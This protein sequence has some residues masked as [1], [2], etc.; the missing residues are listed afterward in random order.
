L[1]QRTASAMRPLI[2]SKSDLAGGA[3]RAA[4]RLHCALVAAQVEST[5]LV[6]SRG[7]EDRRVQGPATSL[8]R[9]SA[10]IPAV[11]DNLPAMMQ[12]STNPINRSPAWTG[13]V[14]ARR[15]NAL[16]ADV[17]NLHWTCGGF[18]S[19]EEIGRITKPLVWTLHD[20]WA[21]CGAENYAADDQKA[22]F[23]S[24]YDRSN[25][26]PSDKGVDIDRW[27][28]SRKQR[29]W[30]H[31]FRIVTPSRWLADCVRDS[32]LMRD[33][34]V[35]VI[36]NPLD[37]EVFK[38]YPKNE[39]R[40]L[41]QLPE[42][43]KLVL[44]G[45]LKGGSDPRKGWDLLQ[46]ALARAGQRIP[47]LQGVIFGQGEPHSPP[48]LGLPLHWLGHINDD[49]K[50]AQLYSAVDVT[51]VPSRQENLPQVGTEA[52][53]CGCPV[54][55]FNT[56][57]L[58]DV[59]EHM[60]TGYLAQAFSIDDL[61]KG[62]AWVLQDA[63]LHADLSESARERARRFWS[64]KVVVPQYLEVYRQAISNFWHNL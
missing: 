29:S 50:L 40:K 57:G 20:M 34:P 56:A 22:R 52:Q 7:S 2:V 9:L 64:P 24:G 14:S 28:W 49:N 58:P 13:S 30:R 21:F 35:S 26:S 6:G 25:R 18:L 8:Q 53:A 37:T 43:A 17:I 4:H 41:L 38:P 19:I 12:Q 44:F 32:A 62:I 31:P 48:E 47:G 10:K 36:P 46:P 45:A 33:W 63:A 27:A 1:T 16:D 23:R 42:D 3:A 54:V 51:V 11:L 60:H 5:M 39:A 55:A 15:I 61:A 59:V